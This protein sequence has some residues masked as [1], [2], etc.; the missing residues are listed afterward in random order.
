LTWL[1]Q[2]QKLLQDACT[3][4]GIKASLANTTNYSAVFT[5]DAVM[6]GIVGILLKDEIIIESFKKTIL[7]LSGFQGFEGQIASNYPVRHSH[8]DD[9]S[10][11]TLSP[12]IDACTWY[13]I[14]VALLIKEGIFNKE[15][16]K[17]SID[18]TIALLNALEYNR[19]HLI[20]IPKG[21]NWADE[22]VYDGYIL[23]DQI[24]RVW[25]LKLLTP[26]Y[27]DDIWGSGSILW[28]HQF[29]EILNCI[30]AKY[31]VDHSPF[32]LS[33]I[34]P[35][36]TFNKFD[37]AAHALAGLVFD[38]DNQFYKQSLDWI[39]N[40]F[41]NKD[42]LP[43]A[44]HPVIKEG[45]RDWETLRNFY[46]FEFKNKPHHYHNGGIWW[47]WLGWLSISLSL[48]NKQSALD[49]L[50]KIAFNY[51][52]S[53]KGFDF[54]EYVSADDLKPN[55][56]KKLCY[57]ATGIAMLCLAKNGFNFSKLKP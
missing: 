43:P 57:S 15:E 9:I 5:R 44:F 8:V 52:D 19:K 18:K 21:G 32:Y 49:Q 10:F 54:E 41:L 45:D 11:G 6:A 28:E 51:L 34:Y 13:L 7:F 4:N 33:S 29:P 36:G 56:T 24:L 25:A 53:T 22:Y 40:Q 55:G 26:I 42:K 35:G 46:L 30:E 39:F 3:F 48:H 38:E 27:N 16:L 1:K 20:Y 23:Y 14:G 17:G 47:I 50:V 12:K 37:L 2:S 31:K